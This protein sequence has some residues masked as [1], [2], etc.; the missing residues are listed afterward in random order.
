[1]NKRVACD[2]TRRGGRDIVNI[3][4]TTHGPYLTIVLIYKQ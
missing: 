2:E 1:M 4:A 3:H